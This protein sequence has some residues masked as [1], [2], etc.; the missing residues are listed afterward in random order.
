MGRQDIDIAAADGTAKAALFRPSQGAARAGAILYMDAFGPRPALD[1]MVPSMG[2][3]T[4][5]D[6]ASSTATALLTSSPST[7]W[8]GKRTPSSRITS[9]LMAISAAVTGVLSDFQLRSRAVAKKLRPSSPACR[10]SR[11]AVSK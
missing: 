11:T 2:S 4:Q 8:S 6:S 5:T 1:A 7:A 9:S 10:A 3:Q